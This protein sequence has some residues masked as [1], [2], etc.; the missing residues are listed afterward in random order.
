LLSTVTDSHIL[1]ATG[2]AV[3]GGQPQFLAAEARTPAED[4]A[5]LTEAQLQPVISQAVTR[6]ATAGYDVSGL[7]RVQFHVADLPGSLLGLTDRNTIW[8]TPNA[9]GY[10]WYVDASPSSN[11][12]F[13]R[14]TGTNETQAAPGSPAYGHV[15]LLTVV[16][17]ELGHVLGFASV[18]PS[19]LD[20]DWMTATLGMGVRRSPDVT[21]II[22]LPTAMG[23]QTAD[24]GTLPMTV[25]TLGVPGAPVSPTSVQQTPSLTWNRPIPAAPGGAGGHGTFS[26]LLRPQGNAPGVPVTVTLASST[27]PAAAPGDVVPSGPV[28]GPTDTRSL[29]LLLASPE[30]LTDLREPAAQL[31][32][33]FWLPTLPLVQRR[34]ARTR[35]GL[36]R[37]D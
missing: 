4:T 28:T 27:V 33:E 36:V 18:D 13:S 12:S 30:L 21:R 29:D 8:I 15:D 16:T 23:L 32:E 19:N 5:S 37:L 20:H 11:A 10:G 3:S 14:V 26:P 6:L 34:G 9:A 24:G 22:S 1:S 2:V 17:H 31:G 25:G 35:L 7:G